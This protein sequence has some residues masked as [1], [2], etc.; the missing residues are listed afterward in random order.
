MFNIPILKDCTLLQACEWI[1]FKWEPMSKQYEEYCNHIRPQSPFDNVI[2]IMK[3]S[4]KP[5]FSWEEYVNKTNQA[6]AALTIALLQKEIC[7][8]G[9]NKHYQTIMHELQDV[10]FDEHDNIDLTNNAIS[11]PFY[12]FVEIRISFDTLKKVFPCNREERNKT[13]FRLSY[14]DDNIY[15]YTDNIQKTCIKKLGAGNKNT[16]VMKYI[17]E[18]PNTTI[19]RDDLIKIGIHDLDEADRLDVIVKNTLDGLN[20][21]RSFFPECGSSKVKFIPETTDSVLNDQNIAIVTVK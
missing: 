8:K 20:I 6:K 18:H 2:D 4:P 3:T 13:I 14:E 11:S 1:A 15:L 9:I 19:T 10:P 21:Y 17:M 5:T 12:T 7:A 16:A